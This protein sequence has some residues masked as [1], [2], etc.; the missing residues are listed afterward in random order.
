MV[1]VLVDGA[2]PGG[3]F[4]SWRTLRWR[5]D[6]RVDRA[7][8]SVPLVGAAEERPDSAEQGGC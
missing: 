3:R 8:A 7:V 2:D 1:R 6:G 5:R 4:G